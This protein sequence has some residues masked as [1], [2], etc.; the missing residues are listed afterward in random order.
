[1]NRV[2]ATNALGQS[3]YLVTY[4][5]SDGSHADLFADGRVL[6]TPDFAIEIAEELKEWADRSR[7]K[8]L[9]QK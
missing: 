5:D 8:E 6:L 2:I 4:K 3:V 9:R 7:R 1:M